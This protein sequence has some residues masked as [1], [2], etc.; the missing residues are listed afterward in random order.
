MSMAISS[1]SLMALGGATSAIGSYYGAKGQQSSLR[2]QA[3]IADINA[4]LAESSAQS[5]LLT[6]QRQEQSIRLRG[7]QVKSAQRASMAANGIDLGSQTAVN[8]LSSTDVMSQIDA[9]T[10]QANAVRAAWGYRTQGVG[11]QNEAAMKRAGAEGI[12]PEMQAATSLI[13]SAGKVASSWYVMDK[14]IS[15]RSTKS[16]SIGYWG[17]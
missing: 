1:V 2:Y 6:G 9:N 14:G 13:G 17:D 15:P 5:A 7:A 8:V 16:G 4:G 12:S 10:A 3:D 11:Y